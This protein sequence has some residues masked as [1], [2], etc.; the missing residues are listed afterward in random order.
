MQNQTLFFV[1]FF[2]AVLNFSS[3]AQAATGNH[4]W[5]TQQKSSPA[6]SYQEVGFDEYISEQNTQIA[7]K[8]NTP[9]LVHKSREINFLYGLSNSSFDILGENIQSTFSMI[10]LH[11]HDELQPNMGYGLGYKLFLPKT[12][13]SVEFSIHQIQGTFYVNSPLQQNLLLRLEGGLAPR[14]VSARNESSKTDQLI[15]HGLASGGILYASNEN[16]VLGFVP[17]IRVPIFSEKVEK[18][19][20]DFN[21]I[22]GAQF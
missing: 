9:P 17:E 20:Y 15:T 18:I 21:F 3:L 11:Y 19:S 1:S 14:F 10:G 8:K 13:K 16:L 7:R 22:I 6:S 5:N 2:V 4:F 12:V